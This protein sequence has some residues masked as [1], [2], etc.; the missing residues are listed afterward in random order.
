MSGRVGSTIYAHGPCGPYKYEFTPRVDP[1]TTLQRRVRAF[2]STGA[3]VWKYF[4][5]ATR[6]GWNEYAEN[7]RTPNAVGRSGRP[8]GY[9]R[10]VGM[11]AFAALLYVQIPDRAPTVFTL[12]RCENPNVALFIGTY[13]L[14]TFNPDD[15]WL[16]QANSGFVICTSPAKRATVNRWHGRYRYAGYVH[17]GISGP[18]YQA[19]FRPAWPLTPTLPVIFC[20]WRVMDADGR[21]SGNGYARLSNV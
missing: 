19:I 6:D 1:D 8:T 20:R 14:V 12:A 9:N 2:F 15:E 3:E 16:H 13:I 7:L 21:L 5:Q 18:P 17:G 11:Y 10:F 4:S